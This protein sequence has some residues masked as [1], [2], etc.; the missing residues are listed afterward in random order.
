MNE[1]EYEGIFAFHPGYYVADILDDMGITPNEFAAQ[2]GIS[3]NALQKLLGGRC[4]VTADLAKRLAG[5]LGTS[6]EIWLNLQKTYDQKRSEI[7]CK[8][9]HTSPREIVSSSDC[10][11]HFL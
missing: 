4:S 8:R 1:I 2:L 6:T 7:D 11:Q 5:L 3:K 10:Q 9:S